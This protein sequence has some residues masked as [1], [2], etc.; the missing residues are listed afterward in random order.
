MSMTFFESHSS[1]F[2]FRVDLVC[3]VGKKIKPDALVL[4]VAQCFDWIER[5][6]LARWI[7]SKENSNRGA[8]Q[9]CNRD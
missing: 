3:F 1:S 8:K 9:K 2:S 4:F 5:S 6:G 7:K